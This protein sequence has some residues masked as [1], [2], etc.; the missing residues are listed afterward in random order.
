MRGRAVRWWFGAIPRCYPLD[1][2]S[3]VRQE[4]RKT[5]P[6]CSYSFF[7]YVSC[8]EVTKSYTKK[9]RRNQEKGR[10]GWKSL[11]PMVSVVNLGLA[12]PMKHMR[13]TKTTASWWFHRTLEISEPMIW[14]RPQHSHRTAFT[15]VLI[16]SCVR[17]MESKSVILQILHY[18]TWITDC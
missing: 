4:H 9:P 15:T 2:W 3:L 6:S 11:H 13:H 7:L 18:L 14:R 12:K 16:S 5:F 17:K 1:L 10:R 8:C